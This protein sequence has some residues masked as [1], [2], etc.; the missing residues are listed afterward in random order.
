MS[1][2]YDDPGDLGLPASADPALAAEYEA[3]KRHAA[4]ILKPAIEGGKT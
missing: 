1:L 2:G 3:V 4:A